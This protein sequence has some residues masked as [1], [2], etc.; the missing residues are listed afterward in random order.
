MVVGGTDKFAQ[1]S[2]WE[3]PRITWFDYS[4]TLSQ[5]RAL[6]YAIQAAF[7]YVLVLYFAVWVVRIGNVV[8]VFIHQGK[9]R[10]ETSQHKKRKKDQQVHG[11][12]F[13]GPTHFREVYMP[14]RPERGLCYIQSPDHRMF[15]ESQTSESRGDI[16]GVSQVNFGG[17]LITSR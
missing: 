11:S 3:D 17:V 13:R 8:W 14:K 9:N 4:P 1:L 2:P 15:T 16:P 10:N 7:K 5:I 6:G 12:S